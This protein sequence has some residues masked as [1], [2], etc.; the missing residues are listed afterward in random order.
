MVAAAEAVVGACGFMYRHGTAVVVGM[1]LIT[2][3]VGHFSGSFHCNALHATW[4]REREHAGG[5]MVEQFIHIADLARH[6]LGEPQTIYANAA[7]LFH[8]GIDR[9]TGEDVSAIILGYADGRIGVLHASN[10]AIP[11]GG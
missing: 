7:N 5:Q 3:R 2:G 1:S 11:A 9:Y 6:T 4:W 10:A 8:R